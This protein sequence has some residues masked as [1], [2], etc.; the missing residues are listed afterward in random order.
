MHVPHP[1]FALLVEIHSHHQGVAES[2]RNLDKLDPGRVDPEDVADHQLAILF[3][4]EVDDTL[5]GFHGGGDGLFHENMRPGFECFGGKLLVGFRIGVDGN[6]IRFHFG[7]SRV[8]VIEAGNITSQ[9]FDEFRPARFGT[10]DNPR[11]LKALQLMIGLR[12]RGSH[13]SGTN[14]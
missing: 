13:I 5:S 2:L 7:Q 4:G 1:A 12:M 10:G 14:D 6:D 3:T 8:E 9:I 11:N